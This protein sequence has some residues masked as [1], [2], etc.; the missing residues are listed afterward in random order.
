MKAECQAG[1]VKC[2]V[3]EVGTN[4]VGRGEG[5][6]VMLRQYHDLLKGANRPAKEV[7]VVSVLARL[8]KSWTVNAKI[9]S[10]NLRLEKMC[11][12]LN[13]S[14]IDGFS[15]VMDRPGFFRDRLHLNIRDKLVLERLCK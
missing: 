8:N 14:F 1:K 12:E 15:V 5:K 2:M 4:D 3:L 10:I 11:K 6:E 7:A 9:L 13:A